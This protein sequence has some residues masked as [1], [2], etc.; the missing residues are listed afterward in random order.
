MDKKQLALAAGASLG[1][2][3]LY[4][5]Q[6]RSKKAAPPPLAKRRL[7]PGLEVT[8]LGCGGA[9][10]GDLYVGRTLEPDL[11]GGPR[12]GW[13]HG[14]HFSVTFDYSGA[15]F[16]TQLRD[17]LQRTGLARVESLVIHDLEPNAHKSADDPTGAATTK[18]HLDALASSGFAALC[19]LRASGAIRAF[20][21]GVNADE[22]GEDA[23]AKAAYNADYVNQ[24]FALGDEAP[25]GR[26]LDFLLIANCYSLLNFSAAGIL[27]EC[28]KRGVAVVIGGPF[29]SGIL[30]TGPDPPRGT[31]MYNYRPASDDVR[32]TARRIEAICKRHGVPLVAAALQFP[33]GHPA[34]A[35]VIPGGKSPAEVR[36][37]VASMRRPIPGALWA[38]LRAAGLLP[39]HIR[40]P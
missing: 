33:L 2:V 26:G 3:A 21:A 13:K 20:G 10:L 5:W 6:R 28:E 38:D 39:P 14:A 32:A 22:D 19:E 4:R 25:G 9:S 36:S 18:R 1:L 24:L 17:S 29:S 30:A 40:A 31:A 15:A 27:D 37:N 11:G 35:S 7:A 8:V 23:A 16:R 12:R 34:V